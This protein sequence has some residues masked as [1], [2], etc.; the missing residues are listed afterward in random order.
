MYEAEN[1]MDMHVILSPFVSHECPY[2]APDESTE[3]TRKLSVS[4]LS[5]TSL[6]RIRTKQR[7]SI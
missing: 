3:P 7:Y 5:D 2:S 1:L 6:R 4:L